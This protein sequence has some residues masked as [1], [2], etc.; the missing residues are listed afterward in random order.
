MDN[1][2]NWVTFN[3]ISKKQIQD[4]GLAIV[5]ISLIIGYMSHNFF[6]I[7]LGIVTL[8]IDMIIPIVF[9]PF[10]YIWFR[11]AAVLGTIMT[12]IFLSLTFY[13]IIT[14]IGFIRRKFGSDP[15]KLKNWK[16]G[17]D[18]VFRIREYK[19]QNVDIERPY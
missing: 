2:Q 10:A 11:F 7:G 1:K 6:W 15:L 18:S 19:Y 14:P 12:N 17:T 4:S 5:L 8:I 16:N 9:K 3:Q 13:I